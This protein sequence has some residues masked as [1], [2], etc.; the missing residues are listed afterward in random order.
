MSKFDIKGNVHNVGGNIDGNFRF[1]IMWNDEDTPGKVD[2]D[3]HA[4]EPNGTE[5]FYGSY[6]KPRETSLTGQLDIDMIRPEHTGI[7]NIYWTDLSKLEDGKYRFFIHN[8][9]NG[10]N[11]GCKAEIFFKGLLWQYFVNKE[12]TQKEDAFI[13]EIEIKNRKLK[14]VKHSSWLVFEENILA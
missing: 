12:I 8:Y 14:D 11:K 5:I 3:A 6:K 10:H 4:T 13:A 1:S 7:E 2:L 9:D